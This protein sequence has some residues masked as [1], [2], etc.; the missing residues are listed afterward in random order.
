M[1]HETRTIGQGNGLSVSKNH[2]RS[3]KNSSSL[4]KTHHLVVV[5]L[6]VIVTFE[7]CSKNYKRKHLSSFLKVTLPLFCCLSHEILDLRMKP[8]KWSP[9][10]WNNC[11]WRRNNWKTPRRN[12]WKSWV[13]KRNPRTWKN[14][15]PTTTPTN[16]CSIVCQRPKRGMFQNIQLSLR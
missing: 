15:S 16:R 11:R 7:I 3:P 13:R 14:P 1:L 9:K 2:E 12:I 6:L 4:Q 5:V 10:S 8:K